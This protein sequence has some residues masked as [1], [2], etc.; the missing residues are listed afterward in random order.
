MKLTAYIYQGIVYSLLRKGEKEKVLSLLKR[1]R[2]RGI[3]T[4]KTYEKYGFLLIR[5]GD[6][7][8]AEEVLKEGIEKFKKCR[9]IFRLLKEIYIRKGEIDK[10]IQTIK[11]A[12]ENNPEVYWYD[13]ILGDI[14]YYEKKDPETALS[15]YKKLLDRDDVPLTS[16]IKSPAR[17]LFKRLS[18]IYYKLGDYEKAIYFYKEFYELKPSNFYENDFFYYGDALF[19][20]GKKEE[21]EKIFK[22]GIKRRCGN[23]IKK[24]VKELGLNLGEP[25]EAKERKDAERIPIKTPLI[26]E[27][28]NLIDLIDDLTK[29]K[30]RKG[31]IITVASSVSAISQGRVYSVETIDVKPLAKILSKF[32]SR[33]RNTP[34]ATT[35]PLSNPYAMQVAVEEAGVFKILL[36]AF[37]GFI[38]KLLRRRGW[39]YIIAG[40]NVAQID[41]MPASMPPYDYYVIPGPENPDSFCEEI[42]KKTSCEACIVDANDL[43]IAWVVGKSSGVNKSW[44]EDVMSD[45]PAGNED[46]QTPIIILRKKP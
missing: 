26:T 40:K 4:C 11:I 24:K 8:K 43:G 14:Y 7:D 32:V 2:E 30:R 27:R 37:I 5:D 16:D 13:I 18:R 19:K 22:D 6:L 41:D 35:A 15:F 10:A 29:D 39:F 21:A 12:K 34:F 28:T 23:I 42:K 36:A 20:L 17:Y 46:W 9:G 1:L 44:V 33:N 38:G 45:N 31:D 3:L 25:D